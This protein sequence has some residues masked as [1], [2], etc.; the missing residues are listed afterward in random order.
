M[1]AAVSSL[2]EEERLLQTTVHDFAQREV[3]PT[4]IERDE[5]ERFDRSIFD[6][7]RHSG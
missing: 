2:G 6:A 5:T 1:V 3:A 7:W 4:A